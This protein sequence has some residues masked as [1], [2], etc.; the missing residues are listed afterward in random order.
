MKNLSGTEQL[1]LLNRASDLVS[2]ANDILSAAGLG[3]IRHGHQ[4]HQGELFYPINELRSDVLTALNAINDQRRNLA[5]HLRQTD[6]AE[7]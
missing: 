3:V 7:I 2:E 6:Q 5:A 1:A 4:G